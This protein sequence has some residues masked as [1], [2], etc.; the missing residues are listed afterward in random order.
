MDQLRN[1][2]RIFI[3]GKGD[4]YI[5]DMENSRIQKWSRGAAYG[6]TVAGGNGVGSAA[7]QFNR[8]TSVF[9]DK[10]GNIYVSDQYNSRVQ[11]WTPG[12]TSGIT[13][14]GYVNLPTGV[15]LDAAGNLYV[16]EQGSSLVSK[17]APGAT[18]GVVVAG[19]HG[20]GS[21]PNQLSSPT[22]IFVDAQG[23]L[24]VCDTDNNRV[25]KWVPGATSGVTIAGGT[26]GSSSSQLANP[27]GVYVDGTGN[28]Y[29]TDFNNYRVQKWEPGATTGTTVAG[30]A[31]GSGSNQFNQPAGVTMDADCNLYVSDFYNHRIQ[32]FTMTASNQITALHPGDYTATITTANGVAVTSNTITILPAAIP[33]VEIKADTTTIC[34]GTKLTFRATAVNGGNAPS[35][36][37]TKNTIKVGV[38]ANL[39]TDETLIDGDQISCVMTSNAG[40]LSQPTAASNPIVVHVLKPHVPVNLGNDVRI[41]SNSGITLNPGGPYTSYQWQ[42]GSASPSLT[43]HQAGKYWVSVLDGCG[44]SADTV[45][46]SVYLVPT[47][48]MPQDT[49]FCKNESVI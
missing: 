43:V 30:G 8:P 10:A 34:P 15:S 49:S 41:C 46:V 40:C 39:Y 13:V 9:V 3:D 32:K 23:S 21:S 4:L 35:F 2:N 5:P 14:T 25:Q 36:Q 12:A 22:G 29:I 44:K 42:D 26:Y 19:G 37:W 24:Y 11:K 6:V 38:N 7:N 18:T 45:I 31:Y 20:Y 33:A 17:W 48:F 16:S 1:P 27:L 28:V 47:G